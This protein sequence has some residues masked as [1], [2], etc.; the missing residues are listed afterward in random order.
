MLKKE[1]VSKTKGF[2]LWWFDKEEKK[3]HPAGRAFFSEEYGEYHLRVDIHPQNQY[4]LRAISSIGNETQYRVEVVIKRN[5][6]FKFRQ[7]IG[8]GYSNEFT[9]GDVVM[10]L[11]PY[12][13]S[14]ILGDEK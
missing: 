9:N 1:K 11:A 8:V 2:L 10:H 5:G 7:K 3:H 4:Y 6:T 13:M 14:L 12:K